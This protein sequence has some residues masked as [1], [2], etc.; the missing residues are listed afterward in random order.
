[1]TQEEMTHNKE[2]FVKYCN[3]YIHREGIEKLLDYL[4]QCDFYTAPSSGS[5]HLNE[6]GGLCK[7]SLLKS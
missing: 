7:H 2:V 3:E 6:D 4:D 5:Y 1:M